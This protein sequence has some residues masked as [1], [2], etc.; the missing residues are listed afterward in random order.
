VV[1][2]DG[3]TRPARVQHF[4]EVNSYVA[5]PFAMRTS[6]ERH[7]MELLVQGLWILTKKTS[8]A[9]EPLFWQGVLP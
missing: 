7:R 8:E 6:K 4:G 3:R 5:T 2:R 9:L 1:D